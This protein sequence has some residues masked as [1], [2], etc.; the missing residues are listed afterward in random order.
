MRIPPSR[1]V[2]DRDNGA[3][4]TLQRDRNHT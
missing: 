2:M 1:I 4:T 3:A